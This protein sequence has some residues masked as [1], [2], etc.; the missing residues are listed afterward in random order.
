M[1]PRRVRRPSSGKL[2]EQQKLWDKG[3]IQAPVNGKIYKMSVIER[4]Y[5]DMMDEYDRLPREVRDM[6]KDHRGY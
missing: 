6:I 2:A 1:P 3:L 4:V 5:R